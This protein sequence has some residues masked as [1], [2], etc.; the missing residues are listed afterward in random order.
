MKSYIEFRNEVINRNNSCKKETQEYL[1]K[2]EVSKAKNYFLQINDNAIKSAEECDKHFANGAPRKLEGMIIGVKDNISVNG[3][4]TT[5]GSRMLENYNPVYDA[6]VIKRIKDAGGIIIGKTNMDELAMGSSNETSFFGGCRNPYNQ[7]YVTGGS[8]GGSA[9][10]VADS[11]THTS[12]GTD[13]GGSIRQP[14]AFCGT[15][16]FKPTYGSISRY[17]IVAFASSLDQIGTLSANIDDTALLFDVMNGIDNYD[18]TTANMQPVNTIDFINEPIPNKFKVGILSD[19]ILKK[20][21]E[22]I[23]KI[24]SQNIDKLKTMG[25]EFKVLNFNFID[26]CVPSY[27]IL[28][29]TEASSNLARLD[30]VRYGHRTEN[31]NSPDYVYLSRGEGFGIE[32]KR[33]LLL[34]TYYLINEYK[35]NAIS[36]AKKIRQM[37]KHNINT[38]F[39]DVDIM[40]MPTTATTAFKC[41]ERSAD[42]VSMYLSDFF[43]TSAN[44]SGCP[45][46]SIPVGTNEKGLPVGMQI[47][48]NNFEEAKLFKYAKKIMKM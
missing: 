9:A 29:T 30:S 37:I 39:N 5:C 32:V 18:S 45:A 19:D 20:C 16:G 40:F 8:S 7:N 38:A 1:N 2:I 13:T 21:D 11:L 43:T 44:L 6:T 35:L 27:I 14:A 46:I 31:I 34:G 26:V 23:L 15:V 42:P 41:N 48:T 33:R 36:K 4:R 24:Y 25:A 3:M 17:G 28:A 10:A 22:D 47:Q 12:L